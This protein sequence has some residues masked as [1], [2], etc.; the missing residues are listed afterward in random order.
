MPFL[1][2]CPAEASAST[3]HLQQDRAAAVS[4]RDGCLPKPKMAGDFLPKPLTQELLRYGVTRE[5][6]AWVFRVQ[7]GKSTEANGN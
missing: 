6:K 2:L 4:S 1:L 7:W 3:L 5:K